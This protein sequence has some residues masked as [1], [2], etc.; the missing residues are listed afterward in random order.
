MHKHKAATHEELETTN[1]SWAPKMLF[2][3]ETNSVQDDLPNSL[4]L[5]LA[6]LGPQSR[7]VHQ[8]WPLGV[9]SLLQ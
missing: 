7:E 6:L 5:V 1:H 8:A 9:E 4:T 2:R 3:K